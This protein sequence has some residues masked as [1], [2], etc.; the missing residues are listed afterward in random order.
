MSILSIGSKIPEPHDHDVLSGRG[1]T[2]NHPGNKYFRELV[3]KQIKQHQKCPTKLIVERIKSR[4]PPGRFLK[5]DED[6]G[7][8]SDI[9]EKKIFKKVMHLWSDILYQQKKKSK[10]VPLNK[11]NERELP[12]PMPKKDKETKEQ[13]DVLQNKHIGIENNVNDTVEAI[14]GRPIFGLD[15]ILN[16]RPVKIPKRNRENQFPLSS[17]PQLHSH[18]Q[19]K[20]GD[21]INER[22]NDHQ[23]DC[24]STSH[25]DW[26]SQE[27]SS[28]RSMGNSI[29]ALPNLP[30]VYDAKLH[31]PIYDV[32]SMLKR[33]SFAE[34]PC[35]RITDEP[36]TSI[37]QNESHASSSTY[38]PGRVYRVRRH[39]QE[40]S[41]Q[42]ESSSGAKRIILSYKTWDGIQNQW[43][44]TRHFTAL[45]D[46]HHYCIPLSRGG[47][48]NIFPNLIDL[49]EANR[50]KTELLR[51][52]FWRKYSIQGGDEPRLHFLV[53]TVI[54]CFLSQ[55]LSLI[56][57]LKLLIAISRIN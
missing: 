54:E 6:T 16:D 33:F 44:K 41:Q 12:S 24:C 45:P 56:I 48:L 46:T 52:K 2:K 18:Q 28:T 34:R 7:L 40:G 22:I 31:D 49:K 37:V 36:K 8:W 42:M 17:P 21:N 20:R 13:V 11:K 10:G 26:T 32:D 50:V 43:T 51:S 14:L 30:A 5:Q 15:G 57:T 1:G 29:M 23:L 39:L 19:Q 3:H 53:C 38:P 4:N 55:R 47:E 35:L 27:L 25:A 9:G